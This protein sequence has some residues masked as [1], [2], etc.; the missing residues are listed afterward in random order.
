METG[1]GGGGSGIP[2]KANTRYISYHRVLRF[3][4]P[5]E[6][7]TE[8]LSDEENELDLEHHS[9]SRISQHP[10]RGWGGG[11]GERNM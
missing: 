1:V 3:Y 6:E 7:I 8:A 11:G 9:H 10:G 5:F 4:L 2:V